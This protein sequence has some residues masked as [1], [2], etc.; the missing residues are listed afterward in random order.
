MP[1][2]ATPLSMIMPETVP[3]WRRPSAMRLSAR[4]DYAL[5]AV[6]EL[7]ATQRE[8]AT[9]GAGHYATHPTTAERLAAAQQIPGKFLAGI[10]PQLKPARVVAAQRGPD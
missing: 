9:T 1:Q 5:R 4:V 3:K 7:A 10:L 2:L 6:I 8:A